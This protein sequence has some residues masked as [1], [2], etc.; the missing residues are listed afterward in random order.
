MHVYHTYV[1]LNDLVQKE[2]VDRRRSKQDK[3]ARGR[4]RCDSTSSTS[5]LPRLAVES[6]MGLHLPPMSSRGLDR[7]FGN[8]VRE[9]RTVS[10]KCKDYSRGLFSFLV[11]TPCGE[12]KLPSVVYSSLPF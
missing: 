12:Q 2:Y 4:A 1:L 9:N 7:T 3:C 6:V 8:F 5:C 10:K 11:D